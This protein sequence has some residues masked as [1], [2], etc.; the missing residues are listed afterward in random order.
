[1]V[2][3]VEYLS[4]L[5]LPTNHSLNFREKLEMEEKYKIGT[6]KDEVPLCVTVLSRNNE[7]NDRYKKV[8]QSILQQDYTNYHIVFIDDSSRDSTLSLTQEYLKARNFPSD[9]V[10]YVKNLGNNYATY[11]IIHAAFQFCAANEVQLL[12]DGDDELIGKQAFKMMNTAY[13]DEQ[14]W[15]AYSAYINVRFQRGRS[16]P[17]ADEHDMLTPHL[18]RKFGHF[19]SPI[20]SWR[21]QVVRAMPLSCHLDFKGDWLETLYDDA[22]QYPLAELSGRERV[23]YFN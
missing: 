2:S 11:N 21:V 15:V 5:Y 17:I 18:K 7:E 13:H 20:R 19:I 16:Y 10:S 8:M 3:A 23:R 1:M 6:F 12:V 22:L 9:R 14:T 4:L